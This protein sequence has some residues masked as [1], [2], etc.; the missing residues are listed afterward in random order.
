MEALVAK[1]RDR[2]VTL[3]LAC[4]EPTVRF[5][6]EPGRS[7]RRS[8]ALVAFIIAKIDLPIRT[9]PGDRT[10]SITGRTADMLHRQGDATWLV[11]IDNP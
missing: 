9:P 8:E 11:A 10:T 4:H 6:P 3:A 5:V 7:A 2:D 1:R